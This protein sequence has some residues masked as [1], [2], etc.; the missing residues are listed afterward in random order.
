[1]TNDPLNYEQ[2][3]SR[4]GLLE[5]RH[6]RL[7]RAILLAAISISAGLLMA[8]SPDIL[9]PDTLLT[10]DTL[11]PRPPVADRVVAREF[12]LVDGDGTL[13]GSL[14][15]DNTGSASLVLFDSRSGPRAILS[16]RQNFGPALA[17]YD[18]SGQARAI[19]GA[20]T[21][22]ASHVTGADGVTE[23]QPAS[24]L[25]LFDGDGDLLFRTP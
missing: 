9:A 16:V 17:L 3:T 21:R 5:R 25:V 11:T 20:T 19:L 7:Q 24:S 15:A 18:E 2:L 10:P 8:Q 13:L 23:R 4:L 12:S 22:V 14:V 1:M 6:R